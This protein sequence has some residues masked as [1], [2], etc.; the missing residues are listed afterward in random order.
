MKKI[1][2][3]LALVLCCM[4]FVLPACAEA[5]VEPAAEVAET[6]AYATLVSDPAELIP[7]YVDEEAEGAIGSLEQAIADF[8]IGGTVAGIVKD[9]GIYNILT[10]N[11]KAAL[12]ILIS[13]VLLYLAIV[14]QFEPLLLLPIAFGMLLANLPAAGMM[15]HPSFTFF[16][17]QADA[18]AGAQRLGKDITDVTI[19]SLRR[20][21]SPVLQDTFLFNGSIAENIG[22]A[23]PEAT[24]AEIEAAAKAANIHE[25]ILAMA[26]GYGT[27]VGERGLRL[28]GGQK[29]RVAIARAILR[30]SPII[31]LDEATASVDVETE[32]QIQKAIAGIAGSR[33]IVAIAHRLSTI[34]NADM[35]L[36]LEEGRVTEVGTHAELVARG[37]AYARMDAIQS[38][39]ATQAGI[40]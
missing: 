12:M 5:N 2:S 10:G 17:S 31:I 38:A 15:S 24:Q 34:R 37:G 16:G 20:N 19:E 29:Q 30:K 18:L 11:W 1:L 23:V 4:M 22:Y 33:T 21:I 26:D 6:R 13:F 9:S 8:S 28:S 40:A 39:A 7:V 27:Q 32:Q 35:I 14:K 25:D 3:V 36:V